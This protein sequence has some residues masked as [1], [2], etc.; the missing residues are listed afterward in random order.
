MPLESRIL[1]KKELD[2]GGREVPL[3]NSHIDGPHRGHKS[4]G[5][6]PDPTNNS[7][8]HQPLPKAMR[9]TAQIIGLIAKLIMENGS[10]Q[11]AMIRNINT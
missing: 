9:F 5:E 3:Q 11:S 6:L 4:A 7:Q 10:I 8:C 2:L 1:E